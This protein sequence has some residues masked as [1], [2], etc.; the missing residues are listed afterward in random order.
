MKPLDRTIWM[1]TC[2]NRASVVSFT[3]HAPQL[4]FD[5]VRCHR[6]IN[7]FRS[8]FLTN[9]VIVHVVSIRVTIF[10]FYSGTQRT[11]DLVAMPLCTVLA[12]WLDVHLMIAL[13]DEMI[14]FVAP[15]DLTAASRA[16]CLRW[17]R[18][19]RC[20]CCWW[21]CYSHYCWNGKRPFVTVKFVQTSLHSC[22]FHSPLSHR[23]LSLEPL[24]TF[25]SYRKHP[26]SR[27]IQFQRHSCD[28]YSKIE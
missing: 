23:P 4:P 6:A 8:H 10:R 3:A 14:V 13:D 19:P 18:W 11:F 17:W 7:W 22:A 27:D 5:L 24:S 15:F 1:I 12:V 28:G 2:N 26:D 9:D 25:C 21:H 16:P 20:L